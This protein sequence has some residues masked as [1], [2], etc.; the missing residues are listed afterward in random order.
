M[1]FEACMETL[2]SR[3]HRSHERRKN[4][5]SRKPKT[6]QFHHPKSEVQ[7]DVAISSIVS[8]R[9]IKAQGRKLDPSQ[10]LGYMRTLFI[11]CPA[12]S[13]STRFIPLGGTPVQLL[14]IQTE[15]VAYKPTLA[16]PSARNSHYGIGDGR[17]DV[18]HR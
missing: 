9:L 1:Q 15:A 18:S 3:C 7:F 5:I 16:R 11:G 2:R 12:P 17:C 10:Y 4:T 14:H 13:S 6:Y 8:F